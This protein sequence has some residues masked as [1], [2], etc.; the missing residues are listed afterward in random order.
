[1]ESVPERAADGV[2]LAGRIGRLMSS[3]PGVKQVLLL[4]RFQRPDQ[5]EIVSE[6]E[7]EDA[8]EQAWNGPALVAARHDMAELLASPIDDR[9]H[10]RLPEQQ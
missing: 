7:S 3:S 9:L 1:L 10:H 8:Y 5:L 2:R 6:W 4:Q